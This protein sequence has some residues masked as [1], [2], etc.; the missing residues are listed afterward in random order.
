MELFREKLREGEVIDGD[1]LLNHEDDE[2][3]KTVIDL[4][5]EKYEIST[6]W[7]EKYKI[8]VPRETEFL[9]DATYSNI[10]RLKFR[11]VQQLIEEE[12]SKLKETT[13]EREIDELLDDISELKKV[14]VEIGNILGNVLVG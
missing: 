2:V 9:K 5:T 4:S 10:L 6:N 11:I 7:L 13:D 8:Y 14:A 12:T 3:R 1:F